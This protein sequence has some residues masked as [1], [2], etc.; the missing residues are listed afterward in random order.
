MKSLPYLV[1]IAATFIAIGCSDPILENEPSAPT[2]AP[3][4]TTAGI[5]LSPAV[6]VVT[7]PDGMAPSATPTNE[8]NAFPEVSATEQTLHT[9]NMFLIE[10]QASGG[11]IPAT[12]EEMVARKIIPKIPPAPAGKRFEVDQQKAMVSFADK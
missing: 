5:E 1:S 3:Q 9:L 4:Q 6:T 2:P 10:Y 11:Q 7:P 8:N 12:I